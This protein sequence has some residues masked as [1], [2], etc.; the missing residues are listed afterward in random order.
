MKKPTVLAIIILP[1]AAL[2]FVAA[3]VQQIGVKVNPITTNSPAGMT[4]II[5]AIDGALS[6]SNDWVGSFTGN[7]AGLTN[8]VTDV[9]AGT[10]G[11][12]VTTNGTLRTV[13]SS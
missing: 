1:I 10:N 13:S 2:L 5:Q 12:V 8:L 7:G 11:I 9:A 4:N 3:S 6:S